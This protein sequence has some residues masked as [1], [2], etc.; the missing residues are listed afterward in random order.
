VDLPLEVV[1]RDKFMISL[2]VG[3]TL[4]GAGGVE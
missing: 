3:V 4:A 1:D 2:Q